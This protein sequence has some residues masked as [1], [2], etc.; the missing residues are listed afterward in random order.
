MFKYLVTLVILSDFKYSVYNYFPIVCSAFQLKHIFILI[1]IIVIIM[2]KQDQH[3]VIAICN[4][5]YIA[6]MIIL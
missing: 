2:K 3:A 6:N 1:Y 4:K 5:V